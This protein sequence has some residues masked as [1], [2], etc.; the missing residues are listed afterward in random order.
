MTTT[1]ANL[2]VEIRFRRGALPALVAVNAVWH[3]CLGRP[4]WVPL[5]AF[6]TRLV[7]CPPNPNA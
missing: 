2:A 7:Y 1:V 5:W 4:V 6:R 3:C